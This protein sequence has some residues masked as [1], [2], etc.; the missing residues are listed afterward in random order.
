[1]DRI[2]RSRSPE[3]ASKR[4]RSS[5]SVGSVAVSACRPPPRRRTK[6]ASVSGASKSLRPRPI[7]LRATP[8]ARA[9]ALMPPYPAVRA[10]AAA[11]NRRPRSFKLRRT[12]AYRS[13]IAD[14]SIIRAAYAR[15]EPRRNPL[16][17]CIRNIMPF[18]L[19]HCWASP[20]HNL[21]S[22]GRDA[23]LGNQPVILSN[24]VCLRG[25]LL[26]PALRVIGTAFQSFSWCDKRSP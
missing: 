17:S 2:G 1:M 12:A 9:E 15:I 5:S 7:V 25:L 14:A 13:P 4:R 11:N 22:L 19:R 6:P 24:Q 23:V 3:Y 18:R 26:T 8:V 16:W 10:S 20:K 21:S